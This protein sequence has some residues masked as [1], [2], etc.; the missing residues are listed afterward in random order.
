MKINIDKI[1]IKTLEYIDER[2]YRHHKDGLRD[3]KKLV[4]VTFNTNSILIDVLKHLL[5]YDSYIKTEYYKGKNTDTL[6]IKLT[7]TNHSLI[8]IFNKYNTI[9]NGVTYKEEQ[10]LKYIR[11]KSY[12]S[13]KY[14][15]NDVSDNEYGLYEPVKN[16]DTYT[17]YESYY[18]QSVFKQKRIN[19]NKSKNIKQ[20]VITKTLEN[21]C[22]CI[23][24]FKLSDTNIKISDTLFEDIFNYR[25]KICSFRLHNNY[26][27]VKSNYDSYE[28]FLKYV[29]FYGASHHS[30]QRFWE[31]IKRELY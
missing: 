3:L 15:F 1:K 4:S 24:E 19:Y 11:E 26:N 18:N 28:D 17:D 9:L 14:S 31:K 7:G 27:R 29:V 16:I 12:I 13:L 20:D 21:A 10:Q 2:L 30:N 22:K 23:T 8:K 5:K 25:I 6:F